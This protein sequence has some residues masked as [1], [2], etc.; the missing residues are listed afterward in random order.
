MS[1]V[2]ET[3]SLDPQNVEFF[4]KNFMGRKSAFIDA[5]LTQTRLQHE[6]G[7]KIIKLELRIR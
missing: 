2:M 6:K 3:F 4:R 1:R 7:A 5:I